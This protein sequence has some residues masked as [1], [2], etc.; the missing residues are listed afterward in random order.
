[1]LMLAPVI[2]AFL[3][4]IEKVVRQADLRCI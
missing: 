3:P 2:S 1:M 4:F